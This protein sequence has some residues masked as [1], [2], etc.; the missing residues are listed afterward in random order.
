MVLPYS[1]ETYSDSL[2]STANVPD[3]YALIFD[4]T[5]VK[6][7]QSLPSTISASA[8]DA[9]TY[10]GTDIVWRPPNLNL[11]NYISNATPTNTGQA[12]SGA[13][14]NDQLN[15]VDITNDG[16][17]IVVGASQGTGNGYVQVYDR[18]IAHNGGYVWTQLGST[19]NGS[20]DDMFGFSVAI[21]K[22]A[23]DRIVI[24]APHQSQS[25]VSSAGY[26]YVYHYNNNDYWVSTSFQV[27][28]ANGSRNGIAVAISDDGLVMAFAS[29][30]N[31]LTLGGQVKVI[32]WPDLASLVGSNYTE[33]TLTYVNRGATEPDRF[34]HDLQLSAD[35]SR[36]VVSTPGLLVNGQ[37]IGAV[38]VYDYITS[39]GVSQYSEI[40]YIGGPA[41]GLGAGESVAISGDGTRLAIGI[42]Y[43]NNNN[44]RGVVYIYHYDATSSSFQYITFVRG[45]NLEYLGLTRGALAFN[46]N[47]YR[48]VIGS[49][50]Y[51]NTSTNNRGRVLVYE[52]NTQTA[53]WNE[54]IQILGEEET[55]RRFG[56]DTSITSDGRFIITSALG[57][58]NIHGVDAGLV[59]VY[60]LP[61]ALTS[62]SLYYSTD[63]IIRILP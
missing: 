35:G 37:N 43:A 11:F 10:T 41:V 53:T 28:T 16:T 7:D 45:F 17:R 49:T 21:A 14:A 47:G 26:V 59:K 32:R 22:N 60:G 48:L 30:A 31:D 19:I 39:G 63:N 40:Q 18:Q 51:E 4:G 52:L 15:A 27:R 6:W 5:E 56:S 9:L 3:G 34:G 36:L 50:D 42:P 20:T 25:S 2:P 29:V 23:K 24:G 46:Q 1:T 55:N 57:D 58:D 62:G 61:E 54:F 8:D 12:I 33:Q 38:F 13:A 44:D